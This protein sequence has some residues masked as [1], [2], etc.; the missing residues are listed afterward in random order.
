MKATKPFILRSEYR[1][2]LGFWILNTRPSLAR[3]LTFAIPI[4]WI[5][6]CTLQAICNESF[7]IAIGSALL[8]L[9]L[10]HQKSR[11]TK[12]RQWNK[13]IMYLVITLQSGESSGFQQPLS[14]LATSQSLQS[15]KYDCNTWQ[16]VKWPTFSKISK[17]VWW[18]E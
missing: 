8:Y 10:H 9:D 3:R 14:F 7:D 16:S 1:V 4:S 13:Y 17:K 5:R 15:A 2:Y 18:Y 11:S 6:V 12:Q